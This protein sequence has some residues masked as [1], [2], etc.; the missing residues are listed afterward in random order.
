MQKSKKIILVVLMLVMAL[1]VSML[2]VACKSSKATLTFTYTLPEGR[3]ESDVSGKLPNAIT[4]DVG[5]DVTVPDTTFSVNGCKLL[6]WTDGETTYVV[7]DTITLTASRT[8]TAVFNVG[9]VGADGYAYLEDGNITFPFGDNEVTVPYVQGTAEYDFTVADEATRGHLWWNETNKTFKVK[10]WATATNEYVLYLP[11]D[12]SINTSLVLT[13]QDQTTA[14]VS[15]EIGGSAW[16]TG[17]YVAIDGTSDEFQFT[18]SGDTYLPIGDEFRF[19]TGFTVERE[20]ALYGAYVLYDDTF[21]G[22]YTSGNDKLEL[23]AYGFATYKGQSGTYVERDD[24]TEFDGY[25]FVLFTNEDR[26]QDVTMKLADGT[27]TAVGNEIGAYQVWDPTAA[28]K[29]KQRLVLDGE[30]GVLLQNKQYSFSRAETV[31]TGSYNVLGNNEFSLGDFVLTDE[32]AELPEEYVKGMRFKIT[33]FNYG[34]DEEVGYV[35]YNAALY[36]EYATADGSATLVLDGYGNAEYTVNGQSVFTGTCS[37]VNDLVLVVSSDD[38]AVF[39]IKGATFQKVGAEIGTYFLY[40]VLNGL[41][42]DAALY[43]NG[44]GEAILMSY[45]ENTEKYDQVKTGKYV[46]VANSS[47]EWTVTFDGLTMRVKVMEIDFGSYYEPYI[48]PVYLVYNAEWD[49][50]YT[51]GTSKLILDGYGFTATYT[52][53]DSITGSFTVTDS[54]VTIIDSDG[55]RAVFR[56]SNDNTFAVAD[57]SAGLHYMYDLDTQ[58]VSDAA[59]LLLDG[60]TTAKFI[61]GNT[62]TEGTYALLA[63]SEDEFQFTAQGLTFRFKLGYLQ[64]YGITVYIRYNENWSGEYTND[65]QKIVLDGYGNVAYTD[66][67][68]DTETFTCTVAGSQGTV[69]TFQYSYYTTYTFLLDKENNTFERAYDPAGYYN[70]YD[71]DTISG[72]TRVFLDGKGNAEISVYNIQTKLYEVTASGT[73]AAEGSSSSVFTFTPTSGSVQAFTFKVDEK[74]G[75]NIYR[76]ADAASGTFTCIVGEYTYTFTADGFGSAT[77]V[78]YDEYNDRR[79]RDGEYT[80]EGNTVTFKVISES[81]GF[82]IFEAVLTIDTTTHTFTVVSQD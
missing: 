18:V 64:N 69:V 72:Y 71:G 23:D 28:E 10:E 6:G 34:G 40:D 30:G 51:N 27:F 32:D 82:V 29:G 42:E 79:E 56:L 21:A 16:A 22:T 5:A 20:D 66:V 50:E 80:I 17:S 38:T 75:Y 61:Q 33:V 78:H 25:K 57:E 58:T 13:L 67:Y 49:G 35:I 9:Y 41:K 55:N 7:D 70:F 44:R 59:Q 52:G 43:F 39:Q 76:L 46:A 8:L 14:T 62:V 68:G 11:S 77:Y 24:L 81:W 26:T 48:L 74:D 63:D 36:G 31:A 4:V 37:I 73:Y 12:G 54:I 60:L 65:E 1:S 53:T 15:L 47:D 3:T 19:K 45:N 2:V